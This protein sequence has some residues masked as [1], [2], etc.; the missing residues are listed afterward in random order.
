MLAQFK[1]FHRI[2][3]KWTA[4]G[5]VLMRRK[6]PS[7]FFCRTVPKQ[8]RPSSKTWECVGTFKY[9]KTNEQTKQGGVT[10]CRNY[11]LPRV[12]TS[13]LETDYTSTSQ[14]H[15]SRQID[16]VNSG[17]HLVFVIKVIIQTSSSLFLL[18]TARWHHWLK[19]FNTDRLTK[20]GLFIEE[21]L[22]NQV[23]LENV[24]LYFG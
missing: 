21:Y 17:G 20:T 12:T 23:K 18:T 5:R 19:K 14:D 10:I 22:L 2:N 13:H 11:N 7:R 8:N 24:D 6:W 16:V 3:E 1:E 9:L 4:V 15:L